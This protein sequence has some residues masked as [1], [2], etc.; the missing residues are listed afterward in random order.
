MTAEANAAIQ[1][2]LDGGATTV[3]VNDSHWTM[4]N[5]LAEELH[6]AAELMSGGPKPRSMMEGIER[7]SDVAF[8]IGYHAKAGT[9]NAVL[10]HTYTDRILDVRLSGR[11]VGELGLNAALAGAFGVP[12]NLVSGDAALVKEAM[13]LLGADLV[14]VETK[15]AVSRHAARN[16]APGLSCQRLREAATRAMRARRTPLTLP[17]PIV[18]EVDFSKTVEADMAEVAPGTERCGGRTVRFSHADY[19]E[20]FRAFRAMQNLATTA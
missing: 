3:L 11:S 17:A 1:G 9:R 6:P 10:D 16:I 7:E 19:R 2:A 15:E 18:L 12:V 4:R 20:V 8:F 14:T 5:L 13:E